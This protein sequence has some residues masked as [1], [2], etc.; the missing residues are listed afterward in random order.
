MADASLS[1]VRIIVVPT[2]DY[3]RS[4]VFER[5]GK[6]LS[7]EVGLVVLFK[8]L[9]SN[10]VPTGVWRRIGLGVPNVDGGQRGIRSAKVN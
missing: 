10:H 6:S 5:R 1:D 2:V 3:R 8:Y 9:R 4:S 7:P